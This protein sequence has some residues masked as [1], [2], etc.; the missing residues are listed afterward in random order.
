MQL[1]ANEPTSSGDIS[2]AMQSKFAS[3]VKAKEQNQTAEQRNLHSQKREKPRNDLNNKSVAAR[4]S[5]RLLRHSA[6][7]KRE[8]IS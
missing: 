3:Q 5:R 8:V 6:M 2:K 4:C 1:L 7:N